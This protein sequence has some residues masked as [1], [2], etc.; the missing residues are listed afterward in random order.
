MS[1]VDEHGKISR[2]SDGKIL[3][4]PNYQPPNLIGLF[5][6]A[7]SQYDTYGK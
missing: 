2:R 7:N 6:P 1:K 4:G 5:P 3:K